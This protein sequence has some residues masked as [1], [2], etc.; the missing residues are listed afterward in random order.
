MLQVL[1]P[2]DRPL[3]RPV[4]PTVRSIAATTLLVLA[5]VAVVTVAAH[6]GV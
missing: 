2:A 1:R 3:R 6:S 5:V 4:P